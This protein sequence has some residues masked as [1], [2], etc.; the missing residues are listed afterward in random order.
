[1]QQILHYLISDY[2][3]YFYFDQISSEGTGELPLCQQTI[4]IEIKSRVHS[5]IRMNTK[6][7]VKTKTELKIY[8]MP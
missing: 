5:N 7:T 4:E 8:I 6:Y 2:Y 3:I 1:M